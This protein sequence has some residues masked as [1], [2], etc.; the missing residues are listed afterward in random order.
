MAAPIL[1]YPEIL[2]GA[3]CVIA[4]LDC[5]V[6]ACGQIGPEASPAA[7]TRQY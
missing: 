3:P 1:R 6:D 2:G 5:L 4:H 7:G